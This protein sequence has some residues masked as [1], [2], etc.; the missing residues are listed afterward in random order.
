MDKLTAQEIENLRLPIE[1]TLL[2]EEIFYRDELEGM[3]KK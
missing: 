1:D 2:C 3:E